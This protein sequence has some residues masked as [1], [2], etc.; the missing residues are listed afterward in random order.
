M[1]QL[2]LM[3][4]MHTGR[5]GWSHQEFTPYT[6]KEPSLISFLD[7]SR[8]IQLGRGQLETFLQDP[9]LC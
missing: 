8:G 4:H 7:R 3:A 5:M 6:N 2:S 1:K 9:S